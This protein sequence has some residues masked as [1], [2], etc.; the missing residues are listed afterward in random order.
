MWQREHY[1]LL[2]LATVYV[3]P[4]VVCGFFFAD[5]AG[6]FI[7]ASCLRLLLIQQ[8]TFCVNSLAHWIG[9]KPYADRNSPRNNLI[10]ALITWGEGYHNF[11][12]EFPTDYRNGYR[13][14][15]WDPTKW[16]IWACAA[17]NLAFDLKRFPTNEIEKGHFQ[18][19]E[20]DL[21][22]GRQRLSWGIP[23]HELPVISSEMYSRYVKDGRSFILID[24]IVH[25][26]ENFLTQHPGGVKML[27]SN[28]GK[29]CTA[30][31][32]GGIY[33]HSNAASNLLSTMRI[34]RIE[35]TPRRL[36]TRK[37]NGAPC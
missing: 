20:R 3:V 14:M 32:H 37:S 30:M 19:L 12:H 15:H 34:A 36:K 22:L 35:S 13:W 17:V 23:L 10:V 11:H 29:D 4:T 33:A 2:L 1:L 26:V 9:D 6:G 18:Q 31:F 7:Y 25:D 28:I 21:E 8:A 16:M 27:E 24:G 5:F